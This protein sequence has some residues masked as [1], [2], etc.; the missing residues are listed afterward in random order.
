MVQ[1]NNERL[2]VSLDEVSSTNAELKRL[3]HQSPLPE[4]SMVM[5][6]FQTSGRGQVG[7]TWHSERNKN[8]L[9]SLLLYP[10]CVK[11]KNQFII[12]RIVSLAIT[13]VLQQQTDNITIKWPN[14][15]YWNNMKIA[16]ILIENSLAG[17]Q[18][19]YSIIG[20]GINVN[21]D[22]FPTNLPNPISLKQITKKEYFRDD[23]LTAFYQEFFYLY[24]RLQNGEV[25]N[26]ESE[27]MQHLYR[28]EGI[29]WFFDKQ[30][31]FQASIKTVLPAGHIVLTT[32]PD[33]EE[34]IYSFKEVS[35]E[36]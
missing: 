4:G 34:R 23:L 27:Y 9:F 21:E 8:L 29:H 32:H 2:V 31:S 30:G 17:Q 1:Q 16:G 12:S 15:I 28:K 33:K 18:I 22:E 6:N 5:T 19:D 26:L 25:L 3:Q 13:K 14:D 11:A 35:F 10:H 24:N 36:I 20:A 7:N